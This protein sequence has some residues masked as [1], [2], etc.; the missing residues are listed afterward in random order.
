MKVEFSNFK[1]SKKT[2][3]LLKATA[4]VNA[5]WHRAWCSLEGRE[6]WSNEPY[7]FEISEKNPSVEIDQPRGFNSMVLNLWG[8]AIAAFVREK[9]GE[10]E[11]AAM[12]APE[13]VAANA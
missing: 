3:R 13:E 6:V 2:G 1:V 11:V 10:E 7:E 12:N 4:H 8:Q 5:G 9:R